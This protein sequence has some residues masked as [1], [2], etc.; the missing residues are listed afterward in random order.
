MNESLVA[1]FIIGA[2]LVG[3]GY[4]LGVTFGLKTG[5]QS[6]M[7]ELF[8]SGLLTP[9]KILAHYANQGNEKAR[10]IMAAMNKAKRENKEKND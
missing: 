9:E 7:D 4:A 2:G 10:D 6:V 3:C 1:V 5:S 8:R